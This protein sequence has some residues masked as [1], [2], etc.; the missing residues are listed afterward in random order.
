MAMH[1]STRRCLGL[2]FRRSLAATVLAVVVSILA[3][4]CVRR[5]YPLV[6]QT[7]A[8]KKLSRLGADVTSESSV[9]GL[10]ES[11]CGVLFPANGTSDNDLLA[12]QDCPR[13]VLL[14]LNGTRTTDA[15]L[16]NVQGNGSLQTVFLNKTLVTDEGL[17][18][19]TACPSLEDLYLDG[20][21]ITGTGLRYLRGLKKLEGISL[22]VRQCPTKAL[23]T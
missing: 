7:R 21:K 2:G 22:A 13:L 18:W 16:Q 1:V 10:F 6:K 17:K 9:F 12:L 5:V 23:S 4:A 19:L 3:Y 15:G 14:S 11:A 20:D 8:V